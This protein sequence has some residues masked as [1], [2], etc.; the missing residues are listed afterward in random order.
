MNK[1]LLITKHFLDNK[2]GGSRATTGFINV[3]TRTFKEIT[4]I[5][6]AGNNI[7]P[8]CVPQELML[9]ACSDH[10][11]RWLKGVA[12]LFGSLH[13]FTGFI[14]KHL[15]KNSY[16]TIIFDG[17]LVSWRLMKSA[18]R[19]CRKV[20]TLHHNCEWDYFRTN[21]MPFPVRLPHLLCIR[22]AEKQALKRSLISLTLTE[23][24]KIRL[25]E[26]Y[27]PV[28]GGSLYTFG[29]FAEPETIFNFTGG[30]LPGRP[31]DPEFIITGSLAFEQ[32]SLSIINFLK[33][34][35]PLLKARLPSCRLT[36]A[37]SNPG[38]ALIRTIARHVDVRLISDSPDMKESVSEADYYICPVDSGSGIKMRIL[39]PLSLG[40]PVLTHEVSARGYENLVEKGFMFRYKTCSEFVASLNTMLEKEIDR[41]AMIK[42]YH[43]MF[44]FDRGAEKLRAIMKLSQNRS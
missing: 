42:E 21:R 41:H 40:I 29:V 28:T 26:L 23:S 43:A 15:D 30:S 34:Y 37:G 2:T 18:L 27:G 31:E 24:D 39:D 6:P 16:D 9:I 36:I 19:H 32:S 4:V 10:R 3:L 12:L 8:L 33:S 20:I 44:S 25:L 35:Y 11:P 17:S 13:R 14:K 38:K 5:Y 7:V 22:L 1:I